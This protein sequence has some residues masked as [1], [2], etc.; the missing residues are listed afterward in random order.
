MRLSAIMLLVLLTAQ[1][2]AQHYTRDAGIRAG[3]YPALCYRQYTDENNYS[4][5]MEGT[6]PANASGIFSQYG[7]CVWFWRSYGH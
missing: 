2:Y 1:L 4:E 7:F 5:V 3:S 6:C